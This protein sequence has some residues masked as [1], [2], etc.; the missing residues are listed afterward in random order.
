MSSITRVGED[1]GLAYCPLYVTIFFSKITF[2]F[3]RRYLIATLSLLTCFKFSF[4]QLK[5][6]I[7]VAVKSNV[8]P[9]PTIMNDFE[10][11]LKIVKGTLDDI[12]YKI[13]CPLLQIHC[14]CE[15]DNQH[16]VRNVI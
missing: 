3:I 7:K 10:D 1:W 14:Y 2:I 9:D 5:A 4:Q 8:V 16:E 12:E 11:L 6:L 13:I 15:S